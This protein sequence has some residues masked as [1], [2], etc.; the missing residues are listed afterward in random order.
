[1]SLFTLH[2][3]SFYPFPSL[4]KIMHYCISVFIAI[5]LYIS[6][7]YLCLH[8]ILKI[9]WTNGIRA[10]YSLLFFSACPQWGK[11][12]KSWVLSLFIMRK[13]DLSCSS[14]LPWWEKIKKMGQKIL[15]N[16]CLRNPSCNRGM[17]WWTILCKSFDG[18][19]HAMH[20]TWAKDFPPSRYK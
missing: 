18:Y 19:Q 16:R 14:D 8:F 11:G 7:L 13:K 6:L 3:Y 5:S 9:I 15:S 12:I 4:I 17:R 20:L 1:M 10:S 2:F